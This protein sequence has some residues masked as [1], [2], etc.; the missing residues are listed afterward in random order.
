MSKYFLDKFVKSLREKSGLTQ[1]E[2]AQKLGIGFSTL[3]MAELGSTSIPQ[4]DF[5][6]AISKH[7][8]I[9]EDEALQAVLYYD[10]LDYF[11]FN[12]DAN[13]LSLYTCH[14]Y[15]NGYRIV[16]T[17]AFLKLNPNKF[18][19]TISKMDEDHFINHLLQ[20]KREN[21]YKLLEIDVDGFFGFAT[22]VKKGNNPTKLVISVISPELVF[23]DVENNPTSYHLCA[24][25]ISRSVSSLYPE[26]DYTNTFISFVYNDIKGLHNKYI[27]DDILQKEK[28]KCCNFNFV[29]VNPIENKYDILY[30]KHN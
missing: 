9:S 2:F 5:L 12:K 26:F 20:K 27:D 16:D 14:L 28:N 21:P 8:N 25:A 13:A 24:D 18:G 23:A 30:Y 17:K 1:L 4:K 7:C 29:Y 10:Y 6:A 19:Y 15:N 3:K 11:S 22:C